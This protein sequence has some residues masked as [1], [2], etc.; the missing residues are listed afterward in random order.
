MT[1]APRRCGL[2]AVAMALRA[3]LDATPERDAENV[4]A[5]MLALSYEHPRRFS[6]T[7]RT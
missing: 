5:K 1:P 6:E 2:E 4:S 3:V 7:T